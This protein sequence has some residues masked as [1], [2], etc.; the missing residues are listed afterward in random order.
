M[1]FDFQ[2]SKKAMQLF[3]ITALP[4]TFI[5][6]EKIVAVFVPAHLLCGVAYPH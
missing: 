6:A 4:L 1:I 2:K 5:R 3:M